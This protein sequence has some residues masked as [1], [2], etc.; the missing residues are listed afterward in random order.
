MISKI[1]KKV[2]KQLIISLVGFY[3]KFGYLFLVLLK[4]VA[5]VGFLFLF[6]YMLFPPATVFDEKKTEMEKLPVLVD[7]AVIITFLKEKKKELDRIHTPAPARLR[8]RF[9]LDGG[10]NRYR[11]AFMTS[12]WENID[13]LGNSVYEERDVRRNIFKSAPIL[14]R[15]YFEYSPIDMRPVYIRTDVYKW[16]KVSRIIREKL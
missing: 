4:V 2:V 5:I 8:D 6:I 13:A 15:I 16:G 3:R 11:S 10:L 7:Q 14:R 9:L 12:W 1:V